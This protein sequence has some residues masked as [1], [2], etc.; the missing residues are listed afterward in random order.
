MKHHHFW[1][2][3]QVRKH[4]SNDNTH[5]MTHIKPSQKIV[6]CSYVKSQQKDEVSGWKDLTM[7]MTESRISQEENTDGWNCSFEA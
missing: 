7:N 4:S 3:S 1:V 5:R 2:V 6:E